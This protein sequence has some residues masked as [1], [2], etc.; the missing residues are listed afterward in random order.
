MYT[1][2]YFYLKKKENQKKKKKAFS[3]ITGYLGIFIFL[4]H[5]I[6]SMVVLLFII[7][8]LFTL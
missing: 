1:V 2:W 7:F 8:D 4:F 5:F 6:I 3:G